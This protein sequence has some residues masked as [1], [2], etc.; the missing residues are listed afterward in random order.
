M[1]GRDCALLV[2]EVC[3]ITLG[4][5]H[6]R[7]TVA[8]RVHFLFSPDNTGLLPDEVDDRFFDSSSSSS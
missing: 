2:T 7:M 6:I 5:V 4:E 1:N 8:A 3:E